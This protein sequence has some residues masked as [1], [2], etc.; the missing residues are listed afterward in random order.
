MPNIDP[1][2]S[3]AL[4]NPPQACLS[5]GREELRLNGFQVERVPIIA[6]STVIYRKGNGRA[7]LKEAGR[8]RICETCLVAVLATNGG[9]GMEAR[10]L[11]RCMV[12]NLLPCYI[13]MLEQD[14]KQAALAVSAETS[15]DGAQCTL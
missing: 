14:E 15:P 8:V 9:P 7:A 4:F 5:C 12:E 2:N 13:E 3:P 6:L 1:Y 11:L 10:A